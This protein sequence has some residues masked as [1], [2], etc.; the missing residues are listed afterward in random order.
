MEPLTDETQVGEMGEGNV[1]GEVGGAIRVA[2]APDL[3]TDDVVAI[4]KG[5][6][7]GNLSSELSYGPEVLG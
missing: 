1:F 3:G 6:S 2:I 5:L 7:Y 4:A